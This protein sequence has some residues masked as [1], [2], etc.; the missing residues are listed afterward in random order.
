VIDRGVWT[1]AHGLIWARK[2]PDPRW[3]AEALAVVA[4][5]LGEGG[6]PDVI[7]EA[8]KAAAGMGPG[9]GRARA[10]AGLARARAP[11][12]RAD[13]LRAEVEALRRI[14]TPEQLRLAAS[15]LAPVLP[16]ELLEE[17]VR[18]AVG[19]PGAESSV[20]LLEGLG[21]LLPEAVARKARAWV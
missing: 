11:G 4:A 2:I 7:R 1:A 6:R 21:P 8:G 5:R 20:A 15:T 18:S 13:A 12:D 17:G 16:E 19:A 14:A 3:R 9:E 10:V